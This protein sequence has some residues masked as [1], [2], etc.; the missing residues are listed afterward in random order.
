MLG[1][2]RTL[3]A[4]QALGVDGYEKQRERTV[5]QFAGMTDKFRE[6]MKEF[7]TTGSKNMIF[8][9]DLKN[10]VHMIEDN[11]EDMALVLQMMK[12]Y[13]RLYIYQKFQFKLLVQHII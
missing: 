1:G 11:P 8:T 7:S 2:C 3:F 6:K 9:E 4:V 13:N 12:R 10:M 5:Q